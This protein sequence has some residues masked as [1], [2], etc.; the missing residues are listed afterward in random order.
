L[1]TYFY[2]SPPATGTIVNPLDGSLT[3]LGRTLVHDMQTTLHNEL[4]LLPN[5]ALRRGE[6]LLRGW[7]IRR[8]SLREIA[9]TK[10]SLQPTDLKPDL[11]QKGVDLRIGLDIARLSLQHLVDTIVVVTG[12]SDM[13][14]AFKFAR[15]EGI[16]VYLDPLRGPVKR[17]LRVHA[18]VVL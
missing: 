5:V 9:R 14:P 2:D 11:E 12:D 13:I 3:N 17:E 7:R 1:R 18:D 10:R 15:R 16:R 8:G 6:L 4:E